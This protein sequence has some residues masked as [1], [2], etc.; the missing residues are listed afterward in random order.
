MCSA[1]ITSTGCPAGVDLGATTVTPEAKGQYIHRCQRGSCA[2]Y[3]RRVSVSVK[4][5]TTPKGEKSHGTAVKEIGCE[6]SELLGR[7]L[8]AATRNSISLQKGQRPKADEGA[9]DAAP[10][11]TEET[12][13]G[14]WK[15]GLLHGDC[16]ERSS[17]GA[18]QPVTVHRHEDK[19]N[20]ARNPGPRTPARRSRAAPFSLCN[21]RVLPEQSS[22]YSS[23]HSR[24]NSAVGVL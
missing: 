9:E 6:V 1:G 24:T 10:E 17:A 13:E 11:R 19:P 8:L 5:L 21:S 18:R 12:L 4:T 7:H 16:Q 2:T 3:R 23:I 20:L 22:A 14:W 15:E